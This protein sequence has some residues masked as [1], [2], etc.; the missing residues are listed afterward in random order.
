[1]WL[2]PVC[3]L[4][5]KASPTAVKITFESA[6]SASFA[7]PVPRPPQP[8]RPTFSVSPG[9]TAAARPCDDKTNGAAKPTAAAA[10]ELFKKSRREVIDV[11]FMLM[12]GLSGF[13]RRVKPR[14]QVFGLV[15]SRLN[16]TEQRKRV[17]LPQYLVRSPA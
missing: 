7:A 3:R 17:P 2:N 6:A 12:S 13:T 4:S 9:D 11:S 5:A 14:E 1:M 15:R 16:S 8:T 10:L